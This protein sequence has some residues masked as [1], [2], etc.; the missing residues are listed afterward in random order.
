MDDI[1][2]F[3]NKIPIVIGVTGHRNIVKD[4][5][6]DIAEVVKKVFQRLKIYAKNQ[7]MTMIR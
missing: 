5:S 6:P 3:K 7:K 4:D 2:K 1:N